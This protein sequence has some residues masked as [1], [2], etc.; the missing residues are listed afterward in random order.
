MTDLA[1]YE[2]ELENVRTAIDEIEAGAQRWSF[3]TVNGNVRTFEAADIRWL[4]AR[5][6]TLM[7]RIARLSRGGG[8]R[9]VQV[10]PR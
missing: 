2:T 1:R 3:T 9:M 5:E 4:Y 10:V 7:K 6:A 8:M